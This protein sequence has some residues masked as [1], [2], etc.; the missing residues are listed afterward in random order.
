MLHEVLWMSLLFFLSPRF[1]GRTGVWLH[2]AKIILS[3]KALSAKLLSVLIFPNHCSI[4]HFANSGASYPVFWFV[5]FA[6]FPLPVLV[7]GYRQC[8]CSLLHVNFLSILEEVAPR[9]SGGG[10]TNFYLCVILMLLLMD[11]LGVGFGFAGLFFLLSDLISI[12]NKVIFM[13]MGLPP[14]PSWHY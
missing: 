7:C 5:R 10:L 12:A 11:W 4:T 9:G 3:K 13:F 6:Q 1:P 14:T 8:L 2:L